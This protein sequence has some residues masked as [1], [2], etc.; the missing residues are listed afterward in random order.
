MFFLAANLFAQPP[1]H[2]AYVYPAG[3]KQGGTFTAV[4]GGQFFFSTTNF[5]V[6]VDGGCATAKVITY[7][8]PLKPE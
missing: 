7:D 3:G 4:I 8:R 6:F 5:S 1:P 2:I